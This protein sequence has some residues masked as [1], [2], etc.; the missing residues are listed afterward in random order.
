MSYGAGNA[1]DSDHELQWLWPW[2]RPEAVALVRPLAWE[3]PYAMVGKTAVAEKAIWDPTERRI[4]AEE[5]KVEELAR[6]SQN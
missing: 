2:H 3:L 5:T 1:Q 6:N 4:W